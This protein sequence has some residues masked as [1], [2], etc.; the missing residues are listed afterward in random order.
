MQAG[1]PQPE[2]AAVAGRYVDE[3]QAYAIRNIPHF[4]QGLYRDIDLNGAI[5]FYLRR[6]VRSLGAFLKLGADDVVA[7]IGAGYGWL[8]IAFALGTEARV[9]AVDADEPRLEAAREIAAV[10]GV[11]NRIEWRPGSLG[12][13]P[14]G[15]REARVA[16]CIEVIEHIGRSRPAVRDL[17]RVTEEA[18]VITTPNLYFPIIAHDSGLPFCHWLPRPLRAHY[19]KLFR[20]T[21]RENDNLFWSP[22]TLLGELTEFEIAS[23][24]LHFASHQDYVATFPLYV[25]YVGGGLRRGDG[26]LKSTYYKAAA[27]LHKHS[28]YVMPSLACTLRRRR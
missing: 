9:I 11:E 16:Y 8:S 20:R 18:L 5:D 17:G 26:R 21:N 15:D 1:G 12:R 7:D 25:P 27:L 28:I 13:L 14:L 2:A 4:T 6:Y 24:F 3:A 22:R 19:A 23:R 10:L